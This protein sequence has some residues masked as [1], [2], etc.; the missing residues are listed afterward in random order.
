[1]VGPVKP[2]FTD[3]PESPDRLPWANAIPDFRVPREHSYI[4]C[5]DLIII[6]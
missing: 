4:I 3:G 6:L 1:M 5:V 2:G